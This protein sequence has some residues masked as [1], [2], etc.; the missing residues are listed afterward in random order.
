MKLAALL[1]VLED[2]CIVVATDNR[3]SEIKSNSNKRYNY[4]RQLTEQCKY[5]LLKTS[6][7]TLNRAQETPGVKK[8]VERLQINSK[9]KHFHILKL[10]LR[11]ILQN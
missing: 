2:K 8:A 10:L 5:S 3:N 7:V 11:P 6:L 9:G 4:N 1:I